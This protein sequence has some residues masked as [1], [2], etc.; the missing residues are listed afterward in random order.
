MRHS[1]HIFHGK[2]HAT[3]TRPSVSAT[4][5]DDVMRWAF[6]LQLGS[7]TKAPPGQLEGWIEEVDTGREMRFR[8]TDELL[9]F[10]GECFEATQR[11]RRAA[12]DNADND[13][14]CTRGT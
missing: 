4:Y 10:L 6:V 3:F 13:D 11:R 1:Q 12:D 2:L 14:M 9:A 7:Q 8:S 5:G